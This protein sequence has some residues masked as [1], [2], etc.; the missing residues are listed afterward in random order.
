MTMCAN[1]LPSL[2]LQSEPFDFKHVSEI[3]KGFDEDE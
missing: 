1:M 2:S 3:P